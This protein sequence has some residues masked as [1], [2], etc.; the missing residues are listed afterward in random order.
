MFDDLTSACQALE[1]DPEVRGAILTGARR[2]FCS[3]LDLEAVAAL[4]KMSR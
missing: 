1:G 2:G 4:L 3:G